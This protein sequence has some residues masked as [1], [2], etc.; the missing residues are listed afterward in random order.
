MAIPSDISAIVLTFNEEIHI[1]R[2]LE[3]AFQIASQVFV[4]DS[5]SSDNTV[6]IA[7]SL[8]ARVWQHEFTNYAAQ[9]AWAL[10]NLPVDTQW[11]MRVD[12][13]EII[14][15]ELAANLRNRLT[16]ASANVNGFLIC[17]C[18]RFMGG[19]IRHG[20]FPQWHLRVWRR[21]Q[22]E[23]EQ[24]WMDEHMV[25]KTGRTERVMGDFI[26]DN[27]NPITWWTNKHNAYASREAIDLLNRKHGFLGRTG[28][29][30]ALS[31]EARYKR[32]L[33]EN[34]YARLPLGLRAL[35]YYIYRVIFQLGFLDGR[36]GF[37]FHFL[38][39]FWYRYLVDVKVRE[40][41]RKMREE[42][43]NCVEAIH[44]VLGVR[45]PR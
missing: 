8:G 29:T 45:L 16:D 21:G 26:D 3:S 36:A 18:V 12:A 40:V 10:E 39:G 19:L 17:R 31:R 7:E 35:A 37:A 38:Q 13:D 2:C 23:I 24:R 41:E 27:L 6:A 43:I 9:L 28:E 33:K 32:W 34:L 15:P 25:L 4:V 1:E 20:N 5:F 22:A 30:G 44:R 14:S 42:G 11:V